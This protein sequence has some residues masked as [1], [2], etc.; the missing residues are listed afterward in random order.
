M[1]SADACIGRRSFHGTKLVLF[2]GDRVV[3]LRRDR[4]AWIPWPDRWDFPGGQRDPGE[5]PVECVLRELEEETGLRLPAGR[6]ERAR[7]VR[8]RW[9]HVWVFMARIGPREVARLRLGDEGQCI[10]LMPAGRLVRD[11][12]RISYQRR[13]M[14]SLGLLRAGSG[15]TTVLQRRGVGG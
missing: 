6:L 1:L 7:R 14:A 11:A 8:G 4:K 3:L 12:R 9:G 5:S 2:A 10:V 15:G 13:Q